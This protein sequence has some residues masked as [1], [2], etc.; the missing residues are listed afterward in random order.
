MFIAHRTG[1]G[2]APSE[3]HVRRPNSFNGLKN[4]TLVVGNIM[5]VQE[6]Q[7]LLLKRAAAM[8]ILLVSDVIDYVA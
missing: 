8:M 6:S 1:R 2:Q 5:A 7:I 3:R 4:V